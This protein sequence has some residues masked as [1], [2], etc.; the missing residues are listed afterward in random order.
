MLPAAPESSD[1]MEAQRRRHGAL[2]LHQPGRGHGLG[3]PDRAARDSLGE[4]ACAALFLR[5][6]GIQNVDAEIE[7]GDLPLYSQNDE[8]GIIAGYFGGRTGTL[9]DIGAYD[10]VSF[11]NSRRLIESGW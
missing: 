5:V 11:S 6:P 4:G 2:R 3:A 7:Q 1:G 8:E 10:G 9:L